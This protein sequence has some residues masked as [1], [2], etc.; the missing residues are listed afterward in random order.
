MR[1]AFTLA[2]V[3]ITLGIIGVVAALT[4]PSLIAN[5]KKKV[6]I[7][8]LKKAY[9]AFSQG[10]QKMYADNGCAD[11]SCIALSDTQ[12][13]NK[14]FMISLFSKSFNIVETDTSA[15]KIDYA[16]KLYSA[17]KDTY[18]SSIDY[19]FSFSLGDGS[20]WYYCGTM[21]YSN[22]FVLFVDING[23]GKGPNKSG[24]DI[25]GFTLSSKGNVV[26]ILSR[27]HWDAICSSPVSNHECN[28]TE[29]ADI[30]ESA[31]YNDCFKTGSQSNTAISCF[32][33]VIKDNWEMTY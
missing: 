15:G 11:W 13:N 9:S 25:F 27:Q 31:M 4:M 23:K 30:Y 33:R 5:Y 1:K 16:S 22:E 6:Y 14:D 29:M 20:T 21:L 18:L 12:I 28:A 32:N 2:E 10:M 7:N 19:S 26:P 8:Q 17:D 3:L 24:R